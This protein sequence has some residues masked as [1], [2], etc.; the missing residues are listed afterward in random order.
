LRDWREANENLFEAAA[1][2]KRIIFFV[3]S[4]LVVVAAF[5]VASSLYV[6]TVQRLRDISLLR[7]L[8]LSQKRILR[9]FQ[10]LGLSVSFLGSFFGLILGFVFGLG[11]EWIQNRFHLLSGEVYKID[12]IYVDFKLVD[13]LIILFWS[14]LICFLAV[15]FPAQRGAR[16][17]IVEGFKNAT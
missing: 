1:L 7:A 4:I 2:E 5:N 15:L 11:F 9:L 8:G 13:I 10:F 6:M 12:H 14:N 17:E 3:I 16:A